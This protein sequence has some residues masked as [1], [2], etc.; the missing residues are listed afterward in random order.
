M[1]KADQ[2]HPVGSFWGW[3]THDFEKIRGGDGLVCLYSSYGNVWIGYP[4]RGFKV[5]SLNTVYNVFIIFNVHFT[6]LFYYLLAPTNLPLLTFKPQHNGCLVHRS[7]AGS[8]VAGC[9]APT[10]MG[11]KVWRTCS[12]IDIWTL[13][14]YLLHLLTFFKENA[15]L[16]RTRTTVGVWKL[17]HCLTRHQNWGKW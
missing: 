14:T 10:A 4:K 8:I 11:G 6:L 15:P 3:N 2:N 16:L 7:K 13:N 17:L 9:C 1:I 5:L 12:H